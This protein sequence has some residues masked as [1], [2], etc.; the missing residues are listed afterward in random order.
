MR[1]G[2]AWQ[3]RSPSSAKRIAN[4]WKEQAFEVETAVLSF[5][6]TPEAS[7]FLH[8]LAQAIHLQLSPCKVVDAA[9]LEKEKKWD[10]FLKTPSL[11]RIIAP[12]R[13][14]GKSPELAK[15]YKEYPATSERRLGD[16]PVWFLSSFQDYFKNPALKKSLW[17][18]LC[19]HLSLHP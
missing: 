11:K 17:D 1:C 16:L 6:E 4:A 12:H 3:L 9:R 2:S 18:T 10:L 15:Y 8:Q 19:K 5:G 13:M 7:R 14:I